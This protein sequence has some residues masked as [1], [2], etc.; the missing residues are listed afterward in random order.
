MTILNDTL[1][2]EG[3]K[4][5]VFVQKKQKVEDI[6]SCL[7]LK[8]W[9]TV[10]IHGKMAEHERDYALN[11][12]RFGKVSALVVTDVAASALEA[13]K[14]GLVVSYDHPS[15]PDEYF[16]RFGY[17]AQPEGVCDVHVLNAG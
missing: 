1:G 11:A 10:R 7:L 16:H 13:F 12:L 15:S 5:I 6:V 8:G 17:A 4:V 3:D 9:L 2:E 14:V